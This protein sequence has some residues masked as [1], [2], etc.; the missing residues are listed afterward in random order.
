MEQVNKIKYELFSSYNFIGLSLIVMVVLGGYHLYDNYELIKAGGYSFYAWLNVQ[1]P[2]LA[3]AIGLWI[4]GVFTFLIRDVPKRLWTIIVK[5]STVTLT[6]NNVDEIY[7]HFLRWYHKTGRSARAR[8]L[9]AK[10]VDYRYREDDERRGLD[11]S[12]GYGVHYFMFGGKMFRLSRE[13]K[14]ASQTKELKESITLQTIGRSQAQFHQLLAEVS[15]PPPAEAM[16]TVKKWSGDY[17]SRCGTQAAR[18]FS[19]VILP[20]KTK[21]TIVNHI[22]TFLN[23]RSWY[24]DHGI[25]YRTGIMLHGIPG[26]GKTSLVRAL[27]EKFDKPLF[28]LRL[29]G[30]TDETLEQAFIELPQDSLILIEDIDTYSISNK[31]DTVNNNSD[32]PVDSSADKLSDSISEISGMLTLSGLLNAIDGIIAS[33]GRILIATTN[34]L[35]RLDP[36]LIR[37][38]RF[39][40]S[41]NIGYTTHGCIIEFFKSFFPGYAVPVGSVFRENIT[42]ADLQSVIMENT[43]TPE[44]VLDFVQEKSDE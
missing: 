40:I 15:P 27:C 6:L 23:E 19:T 42:P 30:M 43:D 28:V 11:I 7:D 14:D 20:Q 17:W 44:A 37:K 25:P 22:T 3:G 18:K 36:A 29:T 39:N 32:Q 8:T 12:A 24:G 2:F 38:G 35:D 13:E 9:V 16:T 1:S 31:R 10:N 41:V 4:L 33:D 34:H 21:D 5:Q 26:T